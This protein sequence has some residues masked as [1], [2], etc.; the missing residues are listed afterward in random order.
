VSLRTIDVVITLPDT[1]D[2]AINY[3]ILGVD[4]PDLRL[5]MLLLVAETSY[6]QALIDR[7]RESDP[8]LNESIVRRVAFMEAR[9]RA[10]DELMHLPDSR[11][12]STYID[13]DF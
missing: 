6:R 10:V 5:R 7:A 3:T 1:A 12:D 2:E 4:D 13:L 11:T 8:M 9:L